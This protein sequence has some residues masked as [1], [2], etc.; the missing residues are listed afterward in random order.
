[1]IWKYLIRDVLKELYYTGDDKKEGSSQFTAYPKKA[2]R[3][4]TVDEAEKDITIG[5]LPEGYYQIDKIY[6]V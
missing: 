2:K 3:Y 6:K 4:N 1:M 5:F